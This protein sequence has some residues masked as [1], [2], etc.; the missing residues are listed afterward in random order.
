MKRFAGGR[1]SATAV[2]I[3]QPGVDSRDLAVADDEDGVL[4]KKR[5]G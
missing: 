1:S 2:D 3:R 4:S 5:P